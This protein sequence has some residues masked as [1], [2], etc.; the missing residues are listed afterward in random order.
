MKSSGESIGEAA[1]RF[2]L[3]THVLRHWESAGL[4][5]PGRDG[6]GRR[7]Y[8]DADAVRIAVILRN[9][10]A[11][12][13]STRSASC[14]TRTRPT[15]IGSSRSTSPSSIDAPPTSPRRAR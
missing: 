2:G 15:G 14:S 5:R 12:L 8:A 4:L 11:G 10:A 3:E 1:V 7:R 9:K 6:A 13:S